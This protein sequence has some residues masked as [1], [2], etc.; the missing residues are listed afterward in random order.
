MIF[1]LERSLQLEE[2]Y[3]SQRRLNAILLQRIEELEARTC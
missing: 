1:R 3:E 2:L